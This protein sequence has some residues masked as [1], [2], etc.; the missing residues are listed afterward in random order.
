[1]AYLSCSDGRKHFART[2][3]HH[4]N[5]FKWYAYAIQPTTKYENVTL[6]IVNFNLL[7]RVYSF[8]FEANTPVLSTTGSYMS[9]LL[10]FSLLPTKEVETLWAVHFTGRRIHLGYLH[11]FVQ[12]I[13]IRCKIQT[14]GLDESQ[15]GFLL[16][17]YSR[18]YN[19][20]TEWSLNVQKSFD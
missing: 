7:F 6:W 14:F 9:F 5:C 8:T 11:I 18:Q 4:V 16:P 19:F 13:K 15:T 3:I 12:S 20:S 17:L 10:F 1:M 2:K